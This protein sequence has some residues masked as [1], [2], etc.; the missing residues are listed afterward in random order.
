[1]AIERFER[2]DGLAWFKQLVTESGDPEK[3]ALEAGF[4]SWGELEDASDIELQLAR[5]M[6]VDPYVNIF[7]YGL[8]SSLFPEARGLPWAER[9]LIRKEKL[10]ETR[11]ILRSSVEGVEWVVGWI[12]THLTPIKSLNRNI[13]SYGIKHIVERHNHYVEGGSKYVSNGEF[14]AAAMI[15]GYG[16]SVPYT[17][18]DVNVPFTISQRS[19][20][21]IKQEIE[22]GRS[23]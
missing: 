8:N 10:H 15:A 23:S 2:Q 6:L 22:K 5:V 21:Q 4:T 1:M 3:V 14:I 13:T 18:N 19:L 11:R 9:N 12:D 20:N 17:Y 16:Y 7:G